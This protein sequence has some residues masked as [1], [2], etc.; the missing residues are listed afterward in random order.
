MASNKYVLDAD[1]IAC[2]VCVALEK[3]ITHT[4]FAYVEEFF[5]LGGLNARAKLNWKFEECVSPFPPKTAT[6]TKPEFKR[7]KR[8]GYESSPTRLPSPIS[9]RNRR[10]PHSPAGRA[11]IIAAFLYCSRAPPPTATLPIGTAHKNLR[12]HV[13]PRSRLPNLGA[14]R[15][16]ARPCFHPDPERP[17]HF[18]LD[19]RSFGARLHSTH[20]RARASAVARTHIFRRIHNIFRA[21]HA[22]TRGPLRRSR[23]PCAC[24]PKPCV[25][26]R[27]HGCDEST[28]HTPV[29][30]IYLV[31]VVW[32]LRAVCTANQ[33]VCCRLVKTGFWL[34]TK[35]F[36]CTTSRTFFT[37]KIADFS[38]RLDRE[39][40]LLSQREQISFGISE[41]LPTNKC[42]YYNN[43]HL[44]ALNVDGT[45]E[46]TSFE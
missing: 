23:G 24:R 35:L 29:D 20:T 32:L 34:A 30:R 27:S 3:A 45:S 4:H 44:V 41:R 5:L 43:N 13:P 11:H 14:Y 9:A 16:R 2:L 6:T 39:Y 40:M 8:Y 26:G 46:P 18:R 37:T 25:H 28:S 21:T 15:A 17:K 22:R 31:D 19:F 36:F 33:F 1:S 12:T 7:P 10:N 42:K 38:T